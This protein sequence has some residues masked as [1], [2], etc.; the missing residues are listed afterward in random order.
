[1]APQSDRRALTLDGESAALL[2]V[3]QAVDVA[4]G[5]F[6]SVLITGETGTGK[7]V[8]ARVLH[9]LS[10]RADRP[11]VP[12]NIAALPE[13]L[14]ESELFGYERGA[15]TGAQG[16]HHGRFEQ[17]S[18]GTLFLDEVGELSQA[19]QVK[20]LRVLQDH[21]IQRLGADRLRHVDVRVIAAT[22]RN[23]EAEVAAGRFRSDL[24]YRLKVLSLHMPPLRERR[25]DIPH[26]WTALAQR[27]FY[28]EGI[29]PLATPPRVLTRLMRHRWP[30]N[31]R[32]LENVVRHVVAVA[33]GH[34]VQLEDLP[35][36]LIQ[37]EVS[38]QVSCELVIPGMTLAELERVAIV[39]TY[40][41][42]GGSPQATAEALQVSVRTIHY[43]L[44]KY[45]A[46]G[47]LGA[48]PPVPA[49]PPP[50][51]ISPAAQPLP[52][53]L[54][55]EDD[56]DVRWSLGQMLG[57]R[58]FEVIAVASGTALLEH[59]GAALLFEGRAAPPEIIVSDVRMPGLTGIQVLE[60]VR[61]SGWSVPVIL[62]TGFGDAETKAYAASLNAEL[63]D[64]PLDPDTFAAALGRA[65]LASAN[66]AAEPSQ[67]RA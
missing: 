37:P 10:R 3:R 42:L 55:A 7:E 47:W 30:G 35:A 13:S 40:Q 20:L 38:A 8:A 46:E 25:A 49:P 29:R 33:R 11:F 60:G 59:L 18:G 2:K 43:R 17:A 34:E 14:V 6:A 9:L 44:K 64:K 62:I 12:V 53:I 39:G 41:A 56:E 19:M 67:F 5:S 50:L 26:L 1:M 57:S 15:F 28:E 31:I 32:E 58:G 66:P 51:A 4:A 16:E 27:I 36:Y 23:L 48:Q 54:L 21:E 63:L 61:A 45:R 24:Y 65:A 22:H 52:R